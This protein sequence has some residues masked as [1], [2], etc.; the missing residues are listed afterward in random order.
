M[1]AL[2]AATLRRAADLIDEHGWTQGTSY[3]CPD[4]NDVNQWGPGC[5]MC[6]VGAISI[7][8]HGVGDGAAAEAAVMKDINARRDRRMSVTYWNDM[9]GRTAE[10]VTAQLRATADRL[11][12]EEANQ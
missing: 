4:G 6:A 2:D 10:Q 1:T 5:S 8:G 3:R 9:P 7:A 11:D 12:R